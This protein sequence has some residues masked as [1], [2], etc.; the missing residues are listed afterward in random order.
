MNTELLEVA[1]SPLLEKIVEEKLVPH[2]AELNCLQA[3]SVERQ[4]YQGFMLLK[5]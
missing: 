1:L 2:F 3:I 5:V 4:H